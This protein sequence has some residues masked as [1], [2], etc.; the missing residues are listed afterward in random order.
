MSLRATT[1]QPQDL[2]IASFSLRSTRKDKYTI[3]FSQVLN[4][5][6]SEIHQLSLVVI[7]RTTGYKEFL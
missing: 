7:T 3:N 1:K 5:K 4:S 6:F 2:E